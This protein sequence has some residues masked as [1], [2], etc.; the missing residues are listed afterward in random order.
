MKSF[1]GPRGYC[2]AHSAL[3]PDRCKTEREGFSQAEVKLG[4]R[5]TSDRSGQRLPTFFQCRR[6][7]IALSSLAQKLWRR[8]GFEAIGRG[9]LRL[10]LFVLPLVSSFAQG[11]GTVRL[12]WDPNRESN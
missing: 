7:I 5:R 12:S 9:V 10:A 1:R 8:L 6:W 3:E 11:S 4:G 2:F